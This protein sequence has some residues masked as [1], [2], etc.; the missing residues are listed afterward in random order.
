L[1]FS[2]LDL[3][4]VLQEIRRDVMRKN[5]EGRGNPGLPLAR[6]EIMAK[7]LGLVSQALAPVRGKAGPDYGG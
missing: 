3:T 7:A 2:H 6:I 1:A 5:A 4:D